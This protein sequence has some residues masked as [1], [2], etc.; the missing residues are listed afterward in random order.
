MTCE[1]R[2]PKV[3][4]TDRL[5]VPLLGLV[6]VVGFMA[7]VTIGTGIALP[8]FPLFGTFV[9]GP[10]ATGIFL[11]LGAV[12]AGC[13]WGLA[14]RRTPFLWAFAGV[15]VLT[16]ISTT[17]TLWIHG[18]LP[19]YEFIGASEEMMAVLRS[20]PAMGNRSAILMGPVS[21][22]PVLCLVFY[23]R[24]WFGRSGVSDQ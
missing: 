17:V 1:I 3:R 21:L 18:F 11:F 13:A 23:C 20:N 2:D 9:S 24:R 15:L 10:L 5:P 8:V 14:R 6:L 4:W 12:L 22:I 7:I 16:S 19:I